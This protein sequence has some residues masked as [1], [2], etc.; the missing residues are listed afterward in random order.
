MAS[1]V[2]RSALLIFIVWSMG[3]PSLNADESIKATVG[4][5]RVVFP[6]GYHGLNYFPDEPIAIL[7]TKPFRFLLVADGTY[8]MEGRTLDTAVPVR[9]VL[10]P[11]P[12]TSFDNGYTGITS[13]Y[14]DKKTKTLLGFYHA[15]DHV[16]MPK[17]PYNPDIQGAYWSVGLVI[18]KDHGNSF[19]RA[20]QILRSSV[21]KQQVTREHQGVG[22]VC[23]IPDATNTYL[24]AY[25][26]DLTMRK[27]DLTARIGLA[28][29]RIADGAR[30]G[31]WFNYYKGEF[32]EKGLGG[33]QSAVVNPP[34]AFPSEVINPHVTYIPEWKKY[35]MVCNVVSYAD[36]DKQ[37]AEKGGIFLCHSEDGIKWTEPKVVLI[38]QPIPYKDREYI[39]HPRLFIEKASSD[40]A[41]GWLLYCYSPRWGTQA[42]REPHH[43]ARRPITLTLANSRDADSLKRKLGGTKWVNS[44]KVSFEWTTDGRFLHRGVEREWKVLDGNQVQIVF[45]PDHKDTLVFNESLT[46]FKQ[47]I[48]GGPDAFQGTRTDSPPERRSNSGKS[49]QSCISNRTFPSGVQTWIGSQHHLAC[50]SIT[51]TMKN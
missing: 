7:S 41:E 12:K 17:V 35:V 44:N 48:K 34:A 21:T 23:V 28:R 31:S 18:S 32:N 10:A 30:P 42:P 20:G 50:R 3:L 22:D 8:L 40:K 4:E 29:C 15:E 43:L 6:A 19:Q 13:T 5:H 37:K 47:L 49:D 16:G 36:S 26:T 2:R 38:G 24:Y 27:D 33:Q 14:F 39:S 46:E 51:I 9:K 1:G 25:Y 11:G 45:G